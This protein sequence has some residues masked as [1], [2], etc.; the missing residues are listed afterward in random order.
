MAPVQRRLDA[1]GWFESCAESLGQWP[2]FQLGCIA[3]CLNGYTHGYS[4]I[5]DNRPPRR[6]AGAELSTLAL[7]ME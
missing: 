2:R 1:F 6:F 3:G 7:S 4:V 5:V